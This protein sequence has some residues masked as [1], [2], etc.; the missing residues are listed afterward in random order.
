MQARGFVV[1]IIFSSLLTVSGFAQ[2]PQPKITPDLQAEIARAKAG[3]FIRIIVRLRN[4]LPLEARD[5]ALSERSKAGRRKALVAA[6]RQ[7]AARAE[8]KVLGEMRRLEQQR[9]VRNLKPLWIS[10]VIT[11]EAQVEA[12]RALAELEDIEYIKQDLLRPTLQA[13]SWGVTQIN[14]DDVWAHVPPYTGTG[15]VVAVLDTGVDL[16]HTDLHNRLWINAAE[17]I[18]HDGQFTAA[19]NNGIDDDGNGFID[20]VV[21]WNFGN[22][23]NN[24][25]DFQGHGTHVAGTIAGDGT[26]GT[27]TGVAPGAK[28]MVLR[29]SASIATGQAEAWQGMQ[30]ALDNN[31]DIVSF[32]SGWKDAWAPDYTTW[33]QNSD[34]LIDGGVLFVVAAGNDGPHVAAP[35]DVLTPGRVPRVLCVGATDNADAIAG[36]SSNGPTS[37]QSVAPFNDYIWPPGL[38]KPDVSAPGVSVLSC[39]NGGGYVDSAT[40]S[41][42]S[43]ATPHA[44]G[45]AALLLNKDSSL[46]PHE[47]SYIIRETAVDLGSAGPDNVFGY[48]RINALD[49]INLAYPGAGAYDLSVTGTS[50]VWTTTDIWV[51]NN[52]DG[53]E[54]DPIRNTTNHLY[55]RVRNLGGRA[56]ANVEVKFY[57]ADVGTIGIGGFDPNDDGD[58]AD[59]N[60]M[61]IASYRIPV[62]GP[63]GSSQDTAIAVVPWLVP[64]PTGDHWCVGIGMVAPPPNA[65][66]ANRVNNRAFRNFFN[67]LMALSEVR[68]FE[69]LVYPNPR[70]PHDPFDLEF[71]ARRLPPG[72]Q[73]D[74]QVDER[75]AEEWFRKKQGFR[76]VEHLPLKNLDYES[77]LQG[78]G[79]PRERVV[80]LAEGIGRLQGIRV[81]EGKPVRVRLVLRAPKK[82]PAAPKRDALLVINQRVDEKAIGGLTLNVKLQAGKKPAKQ[83]ANR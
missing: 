77:P 57:F 36:F 9:L 14:A 1:G 80:R 74:F 13:T 28:L 63:A 54:D 17:D 51:D 7:Y 24:P 59:G 53:A 69:F 75:I 19:D 8:E 45:L 78:A 66:E 55:A 10:T 41:G 29:Y 32:S 27:A 2:Q 65:P 31:A 35:G 70:G 16:A 15:V 52:D 82:L 40:W 22:N 4:Q 11:A 58:P 49:A 20:D 46:L 44:S 18:D 5:K 73:I 56:V 47:L 12:I 64:T 23:N 21:G 68:A 81:P 3:D 25:V 76:E 72:M 43:M 34:T 42:T 60:F 37:W 61:Y 33:R 62:L 83:G 71:D 48:G 79:V 39:Q 67:I 30:Y 6:L 26:N 38:L 50:Q